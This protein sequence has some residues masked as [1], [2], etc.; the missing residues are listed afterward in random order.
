M[1]STLPTHSTPHALIGFY[2]LP[3]QYQ[4]RQ[5]MGWPHPRQQW[6]NYYVCQKEKKV[7]QLGG[8][9]S[10]RLESVVLGLPKTES[11]SA[12]TQWGKEYVRAEVFAQSSCTCW[13]NGAYGSW[14]LDTCKTFQLHSV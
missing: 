7:Q 3:Y 2:H 9:T 1:R 10:E 13:Y 12:A 14:S 5:V 11:I 6:L 4:K 8:Q